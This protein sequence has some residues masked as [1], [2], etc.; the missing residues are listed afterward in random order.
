MIILNRTRL[1]GGLPKTYVIKNPV[2]Y[3]WIF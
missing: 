1:T 3:N 2:Y